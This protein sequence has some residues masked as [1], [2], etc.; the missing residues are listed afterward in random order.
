LPGDAEWTELEN[1][2]IANGYN[3]DGTT[4]GNKITKSMAAAINWN[5]AS[6]IGSIGNNLSLNNKS[7]FSA[8]P[9]G[10]RTDNGVFD[11]VG[12]D[13]FWWSSTESGTSNAWYRNLYFNSSFVYRHS[14]SKE[15]G[16]SV[17]CVR[18]N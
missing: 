13:G 16:F 6:N 17:R 8:Q 4:T 18:D 2:L 1:Y 12:G 3:Y 11:F 14:Y 7:G 10:L 15:R 9:G 5:T